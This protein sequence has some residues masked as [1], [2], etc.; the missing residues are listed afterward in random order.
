VQFYDTS[1]LNKKN[2]KL[3]SCLSA[4]PYVKLLGV[5]ESPRIMF[6]STKL[7]KLP[8]SRKIILTPPPLI[9]PII[10]LH[11]SDWLNDGYQREIGPP[12]ADYSPRKNKLKAAPAGGSG[13]MRKRKHTSYEKEKS[14]MPYYVTPPTFYVN[15]GTH[16]PLVI[17]IL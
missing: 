4:R 6:A 7:N 10:K 16:S 15:L 5:V 12:R 1:S 8:G 14:E 9:V 2:L 11:S 17:T 13:F 3:P